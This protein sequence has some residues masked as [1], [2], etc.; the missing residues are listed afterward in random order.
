[1]DKWTVEEY[2]E[3]LRTGKEPRK[4]GDIRGFQLKPQPPGARQPVPPDGSG[5]SGS[6]EEKPKRQKYG[7]RRV[8]VD[9]KT[10]D[11]KHEAEVYAE[12]MIRVRSGELRCVCRQVR[13]DLLDKQRLEYI[14]DF[15]TILPDGRIEGVYDAKSEATRKDKT[16]V[17]KR[18]LMLE[19]WGFEIREV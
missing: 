3:F 7:N 16:Y 2:R 12:L 11:S 15:V 6:S 9:G 4:R 5:S 17:I 18:K 14:A 13:F 19:R 10:F 8:T 1:M